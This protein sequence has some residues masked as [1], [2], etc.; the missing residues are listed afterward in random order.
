[1]GLKNSHAHEER[2]V[3]FRFAISYSSE[4]ESRSR[5]EN[6]VTVAG[7][8]IEHLCCMYVCTESPQFEPRFDHFFKSIEEC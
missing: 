8:V 4:C 2:V 1:M 5:V 3:D 7:V 6:G